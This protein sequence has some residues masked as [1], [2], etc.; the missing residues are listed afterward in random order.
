MIVLV[1]VI[2][3][4]PGVLFASYRFKRARELRKQRSKG[5][6]DHDRGAGSAATR[7]SEQQRRWELRRLGYRYADDQIFVHGTGVF[8][9]VVIDTSTDEFATAGG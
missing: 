1:V 4:V 8:T 7:P 6:A 9:G 5:A 2:L 3:V